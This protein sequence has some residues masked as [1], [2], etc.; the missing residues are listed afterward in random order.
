MMV[1]VYENGSDQP[2]E[3]DEY[4]RE[5]TK[6]NEDMLKTGDLTL[7]LKQPI[8]WDSGEYSCEVSNRDN[9]MNRI[10]RHKTV[11]LIVKVP[12]VEVESGVESVQLPCHTTFHLS[13]DAKVEWMDSYTDVGIS[14]RKVHVYENDGDNRTYTCT[15]YSSEGNILLKKQVELKVGAA[16]EALQLQRN[17]LSR[18][19]A[20]VYLQ[21]L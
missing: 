3:Q 16:Q 14:N 13:A 21:L 20:A 17:C 15:V 12:Q 11:L 5:R 2:E 19:V 18:I 4:Y 6:M 7:T 10:W 1:H 9:R 8:D